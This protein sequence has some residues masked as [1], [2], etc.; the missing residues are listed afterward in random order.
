MSPEQLAD[1]VMQKKW[2]ALMALLIGLVVRL[3]KSDTKIPIDIPPQYRV[4]LALGLAP[5][6]GAVDK[7]AAGNTWT[8]AMVEGAIAAVLAIVGH[9]TVIDSLRGGRELNIPGLIKENVPPGPGKPPT[10]PPPGPDSLTPQLN[11]PIKSNNPPLSFVTPLVVLFCGLTFAACQ[12]F[13]ADRAPQTVL[14]I[15]KIACIAE[16]LFVNETS[17]NEICG[18]FTAQERQAAQQVQKATRAGV[19]RMQASH[20]VDGGTCEGGAP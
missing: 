13:T 20:Q 18:L 14:D 8:T 16:H 17:L 6:A 11:T 7:V 9:S 15:T 2:I 19:A 12:L 3:L 4:W 5:I 10:I 1:L